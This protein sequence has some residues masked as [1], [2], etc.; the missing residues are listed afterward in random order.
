LLGWAI[1]EHAFWRHNENLLL[2]NPLS[3]FLMVLAPMSLSRPRWLRPAAICAVIV[4][5]LGAVAVVLK[6]VPGAQQNV[7]MI[8]LLLP[9]NFAIAYGLWTRARSH[10]VAP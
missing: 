5:M 7:P 2:L 9:A 8:L 3:L 1:T 6:G 10:P 4:A